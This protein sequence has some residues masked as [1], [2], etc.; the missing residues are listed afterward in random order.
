[1]EEDFSFDEW[2]DIFVDEIKK[3]DYHGPVDKYTFE[4]EYEDV[5]TPEA[6]A[7]YFVEEMNS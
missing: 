6:A 1:M 3:L 7:K 5:R 4:A 2:F